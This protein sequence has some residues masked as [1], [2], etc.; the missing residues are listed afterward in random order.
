ML[1]ARGAR[2]CAVHAPGLSTNHVFSTTRI[3]TAQSIDNGSTATLVRA[4]F[5][6]VP[7]AHLTRISAGCDLRGSRQGYIDALSQHSNVRDHSAVYGSSG[8]TAWLVMQTL[9]QQME[10]LA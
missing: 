4:M 9:C 6:R 8:P 1:R 5:K 2:L 3:N 7:P 10:G